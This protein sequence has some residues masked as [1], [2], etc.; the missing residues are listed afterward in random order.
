MR[1]DDNLKNDKEARLKR[2][3]EQNL[4]HDSPISADNSKE[5]LFPFSGVYF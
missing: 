1:T 2:Q 5:F 3:N 4:N